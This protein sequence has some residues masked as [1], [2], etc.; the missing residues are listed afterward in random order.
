MPQLKK[1]WELDFCIANSEN[2]AGGFGV[3]KE[4]AAKIFCQ[5]VDVQTS[6]N[7]IW[8][9]KE[10]LPFLDAEQRYL[11]PA[12]YPEGNP[13]FGSGIF[14]ARNGTKVAV[15]N[16]MGRTFMADIDCPFRKAEAL[17]PKLR[18]KTNV[19]II[20]FHAEATSEKQA[21]GWFMDGRASAVIGTHTH[22]QTADE[23]IL[24]GGTAYI[25]DAGMSGAHE[26]VIGIRK[27]DAL[28]R[29][30]TMIPKRFGVAERD[31]RL[32][33]VLLE[34]DEQSGLAVKIERV[35]LKAGDVVS[36]GLAEE[37]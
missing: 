32:L 27:E 3:T 28:E 8:D 1:D 17:L 35:N 23:K 13:G 34:I 18:E 16:L 6:G 20:D 11:R 37:E 24:P 31:I 36:G 2:A 29:F 15:I 30:L 4:I 14:T 25:T 19:I 10:V 5:G 22:V 26:S 21:F 7:H 12:N 9:R 33:G